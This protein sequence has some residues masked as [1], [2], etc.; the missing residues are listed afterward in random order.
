MIEL[1]R[2]MNLR[3]LPS[4]EKILS[5]PE[6]QGI[7]RDYDRLI[8]TEL[9]RDAINHARN[10]LLNGLPAPSFISLID[11]V[12]ESLSAFAE[13]G[14]KP[15]INATGV[16]LHTNLGRAPISMEAA[17]AIIHSSQ[18]YSNLEL[19]LGSGSRGSRQVQV[20]GLLTR[21]TGAEA[22]L[23][24]NNNASSVLLGLAAIANGREVIVSRGE[25]VEIGGG[26]RVPEVMAQSG[27]V[28]V[29]VGSTNR[30]Y[31]KDYRREL[32]EN[33]AA[34]LTVH[35]SNF[36]VMGF[37]HAPTVKEVAD[38]GREHEVP[39]LHDIG[40]GCL[41]DTRAF[42]LN[43]EPTVQASI[44]DGSDLVFFSGD[45]LL[46]GP[47]SGIIVGRRDLIARLSKHPLMRAMRI[48]KLSL[49]AL[50]ATL[51]HYVK[52]EA[53]DKVPV[54]KMISEHPYKLKKRV[55]AWKD[56][57]G[58]ELAT[59][60][61]SQ[62]TIGGGS[63]PGALLPSWSLCIDK[64]GKVESLG[65]ELRR[66]PKPVIGKIAEDKLFLDARTVLTGE[67]EDLIVGLKH[68]LESV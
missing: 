11:Q 58:G 30:T 4:V 62:S 46:G 14:P 64:P 1:L 39:M 27:A 35:S 31:L 52:G 23:V 32:N 66:L 42:G 33:T 3:N 29:E 22:A 26:F 38:L 21:I 7:L 55:Q 18:G 6:L 10:S 37:T 41:L 43:Y 2:N 13:I 44:G 17:N 19:D 28:L 63:L 15:V 59:V 61:S 45:K 50:R 5:N 25:A 48:D 53:L 51:L 9:V 67:D 12:K 65:R 40:S 47:Q 8:V 57:I 20:E 49:S 34:L 16:V 56:H 36:I 54:W 60:I 24:V 68:A